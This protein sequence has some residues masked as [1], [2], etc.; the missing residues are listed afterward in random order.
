MKRQKSGNVIRISTGERIFNICNSIFLFFLMI[1]MVYPIW[2]VVMASFS[3]GNLLMGHEGVLW[4]P[5][6]FSVE[7]YKLMRTNPMIFKSY[8]NTIFLVVTSTILNIIFTSVGAYFLSRKEAMWTKYI[9][10]MVVVTM[11]FNGGLIPTYIVNTKLYH[12][13]DSYLALILP[14]LINTFN[15][16]IM[17]T[18]FEAVPESLIESARL[19][20]ASH[21]R[22]LFTIVIP[23]A[24]ATIA[25]V[26]LYYAVAHWNSWFQAS[27]YLNSRE[28]YPLQLI[29]REILIS[30]DVSSMTAGGTSDAD[31]NS[32]AETIKYAV[33]VVSTVPILCVYPFLQKYF[34][35]GALV[36]AVKG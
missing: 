13:R 8:G 9:M 14:G 21:R 16:V 15:L 27:I 36:G 20:G 24:K 17:K 10:I 30:N 31:T 25:V 1:V 12:L 22:I 35:K 2:Y 26:L 23:L 18:S 29:L 3:D 4:K 33:I 7:S 34:A 32:V 6:G 5:L 19:D 11:F 28:K